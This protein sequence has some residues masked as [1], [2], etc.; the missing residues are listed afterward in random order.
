MQNKIKNF[1]IAAIASLLTCSCAASYDTKSSYLT[2]VAQRGVETNKLFEDQEDSEANLEVCTDAHT[3]LNKDQPND[4][5]LEKSK[6]WR[7]LVKETFV[8]ACITGRY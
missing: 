7:N 4:K 6:E 2:E 3:A 5:F 1:S 8:S